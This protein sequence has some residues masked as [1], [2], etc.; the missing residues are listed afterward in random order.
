MMGMV[1]VDVFK[2]CLEIDYNFWFEAEYEIEWQTD[3]R[4]VFFGLN[5]HYLTSVGSD[6]FVTKTVLNQ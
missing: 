5:C 6:K 4:H 1:I 3:G 2:K